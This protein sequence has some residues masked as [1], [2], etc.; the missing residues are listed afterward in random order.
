[1]PR[2]IHELR[3]A[4]LKQRNTDIVLHAGR[5]SRAPDGI[6]EQQAYVILHNIA[7]DVMPETH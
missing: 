2:C 6:D 1:M 7:T 5:D 4:E 3:T